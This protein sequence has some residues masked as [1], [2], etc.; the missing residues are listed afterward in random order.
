MQTI[1]DLRSSRRTPGAGLIVL[2][3]A[4]LCASPT[5]ASFLFADLAAERNGATEGF[6]M[7]VFPYGGD[8]VNRF[9]GAL[10]YHVPIGGSYPVGGSFSYGFGLEYSSNLWRFDTS[11]SHV[12]AALESRFNAGAGWSMSFGE[13]LPPSSA[14]NPTQFW[15]YRSPTGKISRFYQTLDVA[16]PV[17]FNT[18]YTRDGSYLRLAVDGTE[19]VVASLN[20]TEKVYQQQ[21]GGA[22]RF[23]EERDHFGNDYS[24]TYSAGQ[25]QISDRHGRTHTIFLQANP[26]GSGGDVIDRVEL[27]AFGGTTAVYDLTYTTATVDL[28]PQDDDP[29]TPAQQSVALL[30]SLTLPSG[31]QLAFTYVPTGGAVPA[32]GRLETVA[33]VTG[34]FFQYTYQTVELP[35]VN[36]ALHTADVVG[37]ATRA[38]RY[39]L[40]GPKSILGTWQFSM[41]L[42]RDRD[43]LTNDKPRQLTTRVTYPDGHKRDYL[44]TAFAGGNP[45]NEHNPPVNMYLRDYAFPFTKLHAGPGEELVDSVRIY[46]ADDTLVRTKLVR[47]NFI[48]CSGC[49]DQQPSTNG[50]RTLY[51]DGSGARETNLQWTRQS[52]GRWSTSVSPDNLFSGATRYN[53]LTFDTSVPAATDPW[54]VKPWTERTRTEG[55]DSKTE[56]RCVDAATGQVTR[57]RVLVG[58]TPAANDLL[59]TYSYHPT[60]ELWITRYYGGDVQALP[61]GDLCTLTLPAQEQYAK[62]RT[63]QYGA[64]ATSGWLDA[65]GSAFLTTANNT[66]DLNTGL[67]ASTTR[68]DGLVWSYT[69]D[70]MGRRTLAQAPSGHSGTT[71]TSHQSATSGQGATT[72]ATMLAADGITELNKEEI[73][74][75]AFARVVETRRLSSSGWRTASQTLNALS[76]VLSA[77]GPSGGTIQ[78]SGY[79][80]LGRPATVQPPNGASQ[81]DFT[82]LGTAVTRTVKI[83]KSWDDITDSIVEV[84]RAITTTFDRFARVHARHTADSDGDQRTETYTRG[85]S[86]HVS[87][88]VVTDGTVTDTLSTPG[89]TD[90]RGFIVHAPGGGSITGY[91]ALGNLTVVD[92]GQGAIAQIFDRAGRLLEQREG[93]TSGPLWLQN[94]YASASVGNDLRGGKLVSTTRINRNVPH[95]A[96]GEVHVTDSY[97]YEEDRGTVSSMRTTVVAGSQTIM[98]FETASAVDVTGELVSTTYPDCD[99]ASNDT[100]SYCTP[101]IPRVMTLESEYGEMVRLTGLVGSTSESWVDGIVRDAA[102]EIT[103]TILG[104]GVVEACIPHGTGEGRLERLTLAHAGSGAFYD[105]GLA[106]YDGMGKLVKLGNERYITDHSYSL[107]IQPIPQ[108][109][110]GSVSTSSVPVDYLG[111]RTRRSYSVPYRW[112]PTSGQ[113]ENITEIYVY[114][115]GNRLVWNRRFNDY[116][117]ANYRNSDDTWYLVDANGQGLRDATGLTHYAGTSPQWSNA[118][119]DGVSFNLSGN[120]TTDR[121]YLGAR[122][123]G[124]TDDRANSPALSF[125]HRDFF[126]RQFAESSAS[127]EIDGF[128]APLH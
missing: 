117:A 88:T 34:G 75:D 12:S 120:W 11:G 83:G 85:M 18:F 81:A 14:E 113:K 101:R 16:D 78:T 43:T 52:L 55:T 80:A 107:A 6:S 104:N 41:S 38:A 1:F 62:F 98:T 36:G 22:W 60:G 29:S 56:Q 32:S 33:L 118:Q 70:A 58:A 42:D 112:N 13:L 99:P 19:A 54:F 17:V 30:S 125:F 92:F 103:N 49:W 79:D 37:V 126:G 97:T 94:V 109:G 26:A 73:E 31:E 8:R 116:Q 4:L 3:V 23:S 93:T 9:N 50:K 110:V 15:V 66:I 69:Y 24:V 21:T 59:Y 74:T 122:L 35:K 71:L 61:T 64:L 84:D 124:L 10:A 2:V 115:P 105:S 77:T 25:I 27:A 86:D 87:S 121:I 108:V 82:Y 90:N 106:E 39:A 28:P 68:T 128:I 44:F 119:V 67:A 51:E 5:W 91:D 114:G 72:V 102:G 20:G 111:Q 45:A 7:E 46:E 100:F 40:S 47:Y 123:L 89:L 95:I 53:Y 65:G 127:G 96:G 57:K 76:Q 63:Y 48:T